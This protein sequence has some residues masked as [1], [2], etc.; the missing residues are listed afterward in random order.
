MKRDKTNRMRRILGSALLSLAVTALP[1]SAAFA[2]SPPMSINGRSSTTPARNPNS[3][4]TF[5]SPDIA[6]RACATAEVV[7]FGPILIAGALAFIPIALIA[8]PVAAIAISPLVPKGGHNP[9]D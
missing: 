5:V 1:F 3:G 7:V 8:W 6:G 2:Q 9:A 4:C